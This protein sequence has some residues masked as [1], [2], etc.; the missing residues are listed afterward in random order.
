[1]LIIELLL[2]DVTLMGTWTDE[3]RLVVGFDGVAIVVVDVGLMLGIMVV[4]LFSGVVIVVV[5]VVV[6]SSSVDFG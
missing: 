6:V 3:T 2:F 1:M 5:V 4:L